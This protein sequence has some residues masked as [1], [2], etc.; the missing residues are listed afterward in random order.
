MTKADD[1]LPSVRYADGVARGA[2]QADPAQQAVLPTLD[3]IAR[4]IAQPKP[5]SL[6]DRLRGTPH[7]AARGLYL[8]GG[9]GRG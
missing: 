4:E 3:R 5:R 2:W 9:V 8:H 7:H 6:L 1:A